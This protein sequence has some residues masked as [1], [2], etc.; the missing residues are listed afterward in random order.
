MG[1]TLRTHCIVRFY[2]RTPVALQSENQAAQKNAKTMLRSK[3]TKPVSKSCT[4]HHGF[5]NAG[6]ASAR[7]IKAR[8][9]EPPIE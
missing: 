2:L 8:C 9:P 6:D 5:V 4:K 3:I 7:N 1:A